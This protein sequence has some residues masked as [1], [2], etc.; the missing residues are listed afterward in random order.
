MRQVYSYFL[1]PRKRPGV[2]EHVVQDYR[3]PQT[4]HEIQMVR[5]GGNPACRST[6]QLEVEQDL[7]GASSVV[8]DTL[9]SGPDLD[10]LRHKTSVFMRNDIVDG[11]QDDKNRFK[12][13]VKVR[14]KIFCWLFDY[15]AKI[16]NQR[17]LF[18]EFIRPT[19]ILIF[20]RRFC[21]KT[22]EEPTIEC[23]FQ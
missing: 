1:S 10:T 15:V 9:G 11:D 13:Y 8:V 14:E 5:Q 21:S 23:C 17:T 6:G 16:T 18:C 2:I 12:E 20:F 7:E 19:I 3:Y 4:C 22:S